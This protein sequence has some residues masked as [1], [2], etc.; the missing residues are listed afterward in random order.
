MPENYRPIAVIPILYKLF[1]KML[2]ARVKGQLEMQQSVDQAGFRSGFSCD[3][4]LFTITMLCDKMKEYNLPL[5]VAAVDFQKAFDTISHRSLWE[6]LREQ[7]VPLV[8]IMVLQKLYRGQC[9]NV[10]LDVASRSF[11]IERGTRQ[12]DPISPILFN[13]LLEKVM[14]PLKL[15]WCRERKGIRVGASSTDLLQNLRFADDLLL[16]A[17]SKS[18][19]EAMLRDAL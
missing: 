2:C 17:N 5:W 11:A 4:Q 15:K 14:R 18:Q 10:K 9:A 19:V 6:A 1:S 7:E 16:I 8:Y 3:D 12:G 13:A